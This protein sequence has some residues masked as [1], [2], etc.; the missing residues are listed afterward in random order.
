MWGEHV[1]GRLPRRPGGWQ[2]REAHRVYPEDFRLPK[3]PEGF[4]EVVARIGPVFLGMPLYI[5]V[6]QGG[7]KHFSHFPCFGF[8][9]Q[10]AHE[11]VPRGKALRGTG[12]DRSLATLTRAA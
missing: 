3:V 8:H 7:T 9:A 10:N 4:R 6:Q 1:H 5:A 2:Y 12:I 11:K